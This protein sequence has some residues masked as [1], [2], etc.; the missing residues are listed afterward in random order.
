MPLHLPD[1]DPVIVHLGPVAVRWYALAYVAGIIAGWY[2]I[3]R[4]LKQTEL[5]TPRRPPL[6]LHQLDDLILWIT[7]GVIL[8]GRIGYILAY[9]T[10]IIW[11]HPWQ[12]FMIWQGGMSFHGG[13]TGVAVATVAYC[14][15]KRFPAE[16]MFS[17]G[18][19]IASAA[20]IGLF[21]GRIANFING[22]LWGRV[23]HVP[24]G[25]VFCNS[26]TPVNAFGQCAAGYEPRHP[27]Q[28][29]EAFGEG[30]FMFILLYVLGQRMGKLR[31]P[32]LIMGVF[33]LGYGLIRILLENV[34]NPDA[35]M[36]DFLRHGITM[37]M[38]LSVP[39][40]VA[41]GFFIW[42]AL[43]ETPAATG[44]ENTDTPDTTL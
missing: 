1:I 8:G 4:M 28:L 15:T 10:S 9:D 41:G 32:G 40:V 24:W 22:E 37:G 29:Y 2:Y 25:T 12:M 23:T 44:I 6:D 43:R 3:G 21:F 5:W 7:L 18:D 38:I 13:F 33:I 35:Q 34:R 39:M 16:R 14:V 17:L 11:Q 42:Y 26:Y 36:P 27:S 19:L 31:R 30:L 20:P